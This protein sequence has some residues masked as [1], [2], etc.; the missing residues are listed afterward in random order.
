[1]QV[2]GSLVRIDVTENVEK[3]VSDNTGEE[4]TLEESERATNEEESEN[5]NE[6]TDDESDVSSVEKYKISEFISNIDLRSVLS[7]NFLGNCLLSQAKKKECKLKASE[8]EL[9]CTEILGHIFEQKHY[10]LRTEDFLV[11][12]KKIEDLFPSEH[13]AIYFE[14]GCTK[15]VSKFDKKKKYIQS[16]GKLKSR[17]KSL[18]AY[19][20]TIKI[21]PQRKRKINSK[22]SATIGSNK[23]AQANETETELVKFF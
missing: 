21:P 11:L 19:L 14:P 15:Q 23:K 1:M 5:E 4:I 20:I 22:G 10:S 6:E 16:K 9:L 17:Y 2:D 3:H 12:R 18:H 7:K 8:Q 13:G